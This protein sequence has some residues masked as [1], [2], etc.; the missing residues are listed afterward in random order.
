MSST[1]PTIPPTV[2]QQPAAPAGP[3]GPG[4][5][6]ASDGNWYPPQTPP[7]YGYQPGHAPVAYYHPEA[8]S[9]VVAGLLQ[10]CL[11]GLGIGR[12]YLGYNNIGVAQLLVTIFTCG[13]GAIWCLVDGIMILTGSVPTDANGIPL[14]D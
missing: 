8:K 2:P 3:P 11:G 9:K 12:F 5:W 4:W 1:D 7:G 10:L 13:I 14:R 6:M